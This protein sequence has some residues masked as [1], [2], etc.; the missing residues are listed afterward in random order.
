MVFAYR[1]LDPT[2]VKRIVIA[3]GPDQGA[4]AEFARRYAPLLKAQGVTLVLRATQGSAENLALLRDRASGVE[5]AFVQGGVD[6]EA[7]DEPDPQLVSLGAVA[8]EPLWLFY[9]DD[10]VPRLPGAVLP[11]ALAGLAG[12]RINTG[13][14]GGG[15]GPIFRT[16]AALEGLPAS[17]LHSGDMASV[18]GV[19]DFVQGRED[20]LAFVSAADAPFV[21]YLLH[22]PGVELY[23]F[24]H[25]EAYA[26]RYAFLH[27][28]RLPRGLIDPAADR[29]PQD[30]HVVAATASLVVRSDLHPALKELLVQTAARIHG[31][32]G[33]FARAG[34]FPNMDAPIFAIAPEAERYYRS[35]PPWLQRYLPFW[36]AN[37][38]DRMWIV[39]LPLIAALW[40]LSRL[41]P[42]LIEMRLRSRV[43]RW[44]GRLRTI[45]DA[46]GRRPAAELA[47]E[48][49]AIDARV[50]AIELPLSYADEVYALR[51]NIAMVRRRILA[52]AAP[53]R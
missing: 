37:F 15:S 51:S 9:R 30:L 10:S 39:L 25:A 1:G 50:A 17:A 6:P 40:P 20:A 46:S 3:T 18:H 12:W 19:V 47:R 45:E 24:V 2:P 7:G 38:A 42:P 49:D 28:L 48:L 11:T 4:Y 34:E 32:P 5:A 31:Q 21:Q 52:A 44:Y 33:W 8:Y 14:A 29:P 27:A 26:R 13:P 35:G 22:T 16:L 43:Y 23:D 36:L 41:V 53:A